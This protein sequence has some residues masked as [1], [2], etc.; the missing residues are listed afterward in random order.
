MR[1]KILAL[2]LALWAIPANA[3]ITPSYIF[4]AR[5]PIL[6]GEVNANFALL[7]NALD[8]TGG[9]ITGN[10][11]VDPGV[12]I[13]GVD[14][15]AYLAGGKV[16]VNGAGT[17]AAPTLTFSTDLDS[18]FYLVGANNLG[19]TLGGAKVVDVT[20]TG[21]VTAT[22][23]VG[24]LT[25][26]ASTVTNGVYTTGDQTIG[27]IKTFSS[28]IVGSISGSSGSTT[29]NAA[30][31]T[32]LSVT[33]GKTLSVSNS[34]ALTATDGSTLAI[35]TGGTLG[36]AAYTAAT[37][38][39]PAA[40]SSSIVTVGTITS[41]VWNA[42]AVTSSGSVAAGTA[43]GSVHD[44]NSIY[45]NAANDSFSIYGGSAGTSGAWITVYGTAHATLPNVI[46][47]NVNAA[48]AMRFAAT[49]A[50]TFT[51]G[52]SATTGTFSALITAS[53]GMKITGDGGSNVGALRFTSNTLALQGGTSG[54]GFLK[55][56]NS[57]YSFSVDDSGNTTIAGTLTVNGFGT[58]A[59]S[60]GG[61]G[62]NLLSVVNTTSGAANYA[63]YALTAGTAAGSV[64]LF[65]QGYTTSTWDVA[66]ALA[67][68]AESAGGL[69]ISAT[70]ASGTIRFYTG[71]T[72][73]RGEVLAT[74]ILDWA[75]GADFAGD[76][77]VATS[78]F[79][80]ASAT[81]NTVVAGTFTAA[82][83]VGMAATKK[84]Y[85]DG[86][87][88]SGDT[89]ITESSADL[90]SVY[91]G[92]VEIAEFTNQDAVSV[93]ALIV[94]GFDRGSSAIGPTILIGR[95]T[96]ASA[97]AAGALR[98]TEMG[99]TIHYIWVDASSQA[100]ISTTAFTSATDSSTGWVIGTQT[101]LRSTK[102][103]L[104]PYTDYEG[105]LDLMLRTPLWDF[106][107]KS[108]AYNNQAFVGI[109]TDDSPEFGMDLGKSFN[110]ISAHG[111]TVAAIKALHA[112]IVALE[113]A[114][115]KK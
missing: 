9:T 49:G 29:G 15:S 20:S 3:Q 68:R 90:I 31:V 91:A 67:L 96:Y 95:N 22:A 30:T 8:R 24:A 21:T 38:Y 13:D 62:G 82:G 10:I 23:F 72:T 65:S 92:G 37:A 17:A 45:R 106:T 115:E 27:G 39:A 51:A 50:A 64:Y 40:G 102:N 77:S 105:A 11:A 112:R 19:I 85:F 86:V 44:T 55:S 97:P 94:P 78:K 42:G 52:V 12:T 61:T 87:A 71:G 114:L 110:P 1:A 33:A 93:K 66:E 83:D 28:T 2:L 73:L 36:T 18:G 79:T 74:G 35:G 59:F 76:F 47:F 46:T 70:H 54:V 104:G 6:S 103:I 99:G 32:G 57:A 81:G 43:S 16:I 111:Y 109:T 101:S 34:L 7:A 75:Y 48:E 84:L 63:R 88:M 100:R 58:H 80:V 107:Y 60:A 26:N 98:L 14:I 5:T 89:Y 108:G 56:N 4:V 25:G 53:Q 113:L 41:G 69:S